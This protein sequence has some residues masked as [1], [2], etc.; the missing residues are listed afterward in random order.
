M[1]RKRNGII[2]A[3]AA[4]VLASIMTVIPPGTAGALDE[5]DIYLKKLL[6]DVRS[7]KP[8]PPP[9]EELYSKNDII[10]CTGELEVAKLN[11]TAAEMISFGEYSA[12]KSLLKRGLK[13]APLFFPYLFNAGICSLYLGEYDQA[14]L[15][16]NRARAILPE[17]S[18]TYLQL[19]FIHQMKAKEEEAIRHFRKALE[20]NLYELESLILIG[21]IYYNRNQI[22]QAEKYYRASL[23]FDPE[24][25]NGLIG[26]AKIHFYRKE[27]ASTIIVLKGVMTEGDYDK[28]LHYFYAESSY[29]LQD[30]QS[31]FDQYKTLLTFKTDKFFITHARSL[32]QHKL[33]LAEKFVNR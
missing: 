27:Y 11:N 18:R 8:E 16:M 23:E 9:R 4:V 25:P 10:Y 15:H 31:A 19:G 6:R 14:L 1:Y 5:T 20:V 29:K 33:N 21:D 30:Y 24:Y 3:A 2:G 12:A 7:F 28:S 13:R 22:M 17:F 32:V 26:I